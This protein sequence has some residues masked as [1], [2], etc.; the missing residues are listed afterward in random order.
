M[1]ADIFSIAHDENYHDI[2]KI[3]DFKKNSEIKK[4]FL[5]ENYKL[6]LNNHFNIVIYYQSMKQLDQ[7]YSKL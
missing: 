4:S 3:S 5:S 6:Y 1:N 2:N 7:L